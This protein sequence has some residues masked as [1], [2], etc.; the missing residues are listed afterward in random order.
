MDKINNT[1]R[2]Q[3]ICTDI[4]AVVLESGLERFS[5]VSDLSWTHWYL[6]S[7]LSRT[8][9]WDSPNVVVGLDRVQQCML[10]SLSK[11]NH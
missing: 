3:S 10:F 8:W 1:G 6:D 2:Q 5:I 11:Q 9:S 7:D 4:R